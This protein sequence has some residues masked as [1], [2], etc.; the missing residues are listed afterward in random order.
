MALESYP[1]LLKTGS[2]KSMKNVRQASRARG[3]KAMFMPE[4]ENEVIRLEFLFVA[5]EEEKK[6]FILNHCPEP[7]CLS[8]NL[9]SAALCVP[10]RS[11]R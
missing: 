7:A 9:F 4:R 3:Q 10:L 1:A 11:L 2:T 8:L 5:V 6:W